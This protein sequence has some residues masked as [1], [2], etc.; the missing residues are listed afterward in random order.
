MSTIYGKERI[1]HDLTNCLD[2]SLRLNRYHGD[3]GNNELIVYY[4]AISE[5]QR[6][7]NIDNLTASAAPQVVKKTIYRATK[8]VKNRQSDDPVPSVINNA[9]W[10]DSWERMNASI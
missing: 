7:V 3:P 9:T 1:Q 8:N 5:K 4:M 10:L 6:T 2:P